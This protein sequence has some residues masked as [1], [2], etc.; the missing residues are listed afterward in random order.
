MRNLF[1]ASRAAVVA[2]AA[3]ALAA[4]G[5][6]AATNNNAGNELEA[7]ASF[8]ALG[9][10]ASAMEAVANTAEI[11]PA[12]EDNSADEVDGEAE[13]G[14]TGGNNVESNTLGM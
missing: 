1:I 11:P 4:C 13:G 7:N 6:E 3:L 5:G 8:D 9:N 12:P 14:D 2:G 10:D